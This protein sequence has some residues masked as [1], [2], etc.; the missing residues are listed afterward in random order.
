[1]S[2]PLRIGLYG[3]TFDPIHNGHLHVIQQLFHLNIVDELVIVPAGVP[4]LRSREPFASGDDRVEMVR[5]AIKDLSTT[6]RPRVKVSDLEVRRTGSTYTIDTVQELV[7]EKPNAKWLLILGSDA[8]EGIEQWHRSTELQKLIEIVVVAREG[9]GIDIQAL[10]ISASQVRAEI[11]KNPAEVK[12][13]PESVWT[14]I[15]E[16]HL[17]AS[18]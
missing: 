17:Y 2:N 4:W 1:M 9:K 14:Y 16:R 13:I 3:G 8:Y 7:A 10:P 5:L 18:K 11:A 15:K 6:I 12:D